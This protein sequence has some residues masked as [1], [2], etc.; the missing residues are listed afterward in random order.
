M[1]PTVTGQGQVQIRKLRLVSW[2][3]KLTHRTRFL[4]KP[5]KLWLL[6]CVCVCVCGLRRSRYYSTV[7]Q[8]TSARSFNQWLTEKSSQPMKQFGYS[9]G[10][11]CSLW[12]W[13][14]YLSTLSTLGSK[15]QER[16]NK[17]R[18]NKLSPTMN[19]DIPEMLK[20]NKMLQRMID[21]LTK[22]LIW[23]SS[24]W[25][26]FII[27]TSC[28]CLWGKLVYRICFLTLSW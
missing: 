17:T 22:K 9:W 19:S 11:R 2:P 27:K 23:L 4:I 7:Q 24:T 5:A 6:L 20:S 1:Y 15:S 16:W 13:N 10:A 12:L 3:L 21:N 14:D 28:E 18:K 26:S 25:S 8:K